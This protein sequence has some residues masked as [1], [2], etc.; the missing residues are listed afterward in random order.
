MGCSSGGASGVLDGGTF[1]DGDI[2]G[3]RIASSDLTSCTLTGCHITALASIDATSLSTIATAMMDNQAIMTQFV[4]AISALPDSALRKLKER[5]D[6]IAGG[7]TGGTGGGSSGTGPCVDVSPYPPKLGT[8]DF[9]PTVVVGENNQLLGRPHIWVRLAD[10]LVVPVY[11]ETG[12][13]DGT[14]E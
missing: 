7:S 4:D 2:I 6:G 11:Q 3:C 14:K 1:R 8:Y 5:L 9:L 10:S 12:C 13:S